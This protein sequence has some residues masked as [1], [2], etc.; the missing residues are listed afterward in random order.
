MQVVNDITSSLQMTLRMQAELANNMVCAK[1]IKEYADL[2]PEDLLEKPGDEKIRKA[3]WP[4]KGEVVFSNVTMKYRPDLKPSLLNVSFKA[5]GGMKIGIVGRTGSGKSSTLQ[6]LFRL[7]P[8]ESGSCIK[9]DGV[10]VSTIGLHLLRSNI[11]F[12]P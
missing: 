9:I 7:I 1:R 4:M 11:A 2:E 12:I 10:D 3:N 8:L 5:E 6:A